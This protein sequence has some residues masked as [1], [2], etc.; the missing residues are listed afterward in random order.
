MY[1]PQPTIPQPPKFSAIPAPS[2]TYR[3]GVSYS[4]N[5]NGNNNNN[6]QTQ[7]QIDEYLVGSNKAGA[8]PRPPTARPEQQKVV[9]TPAESQYFQHDVNMMLDS[10]SSS[11]LLV[12][13]GYS[14]IPIPVASMTVTLNE[15]QNQSVPNSPYNG[16][17][18]F[19]Q[20]RPISVN[21]YRRGFGQGHGH[22]QQQCLQ[23]QNQGPGQPPQQ[24]QPPRGVGGSA[25]H[26]PYAQ[27]GQSAH[28]SNVRP[29]LGSADMQNQ[30]T[31]SKVQ[32]DAVGAPSKCVARNST[33][34]VSG[35][36]GDPTAVRAGG[37]RLRTVQFAVSIHQVMSGSIVPLS[38][39]AG[40]VAL[41]EVVGTLASDPSYTNMRWSYWLRDP[42]QQ[43]FTK[44]F[45]NA[46]DTMLFTRRP[47]SSFSTY[48]GPLAAVGGDGG[49]AAKC[50]TDKN[51]DDFDDFMTTT[52]GGTVAGAML[53]CYY[54]D[55]GGGLDLELMDQGQ[56][57]RAIG[58]VASSQPL[59]GS[60]GCLSMQLVNIRGATEE[61]ARLAVLG[62]PRG[63]NPLTK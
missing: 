42:N 15:L 23:Q 21:S 39:P 18:T 25:R 22:G 9:A 55:V 19:Q 3:P 50:T 47:L 11:L 56:I 24:R 32:R 63:V 6:G 30:T 53:P 31:K 43:D 45:P 38:S 33:K 46:K 27:D 54:Y 58:V 60:G 59:I 34:S 37:I 20:A 17:T 4:Y 48:G 49:V 61:E 16:S 13:Q 5:K 36:G 40:S 12:P 35:R 2:S 62:L 26:H 28:G 14:D 41:I 52:A 8:T 7:T 44:C 29:G 1:N 10:P 51:D 57:L